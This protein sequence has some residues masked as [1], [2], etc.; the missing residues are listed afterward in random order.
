MPTIQLRQT[1]E[2]P[3]PF[4]LARFRRAPDLG[5]KVLF[6]SGGSAL[7]KLSRRLVHATHN[8]VH[9]ITPFDSGGSSA[10]L[11]NEFNML[12][13]GDLRNR[14]MAL[15]DRSVTGN[16]EIYELFNYRFPK[17]LDNEQ[18]RENLKLMIQ[19]KEKLISNIPDPM[20]K[21]IRTHLK[22]FEKRMT[23]TFDLRGASIGNLILAGGYFNYGRHIDPVIFLFSKLV[24]AKGVVRPVIN[25]DL[26]LVAEL[27]NGR[28][29]VGQHLMTGKEAPPIDSPITKLY[30][31]D[32]L[33]NISSPTPVEVQI[34]EKVKKVIHAAD[35][36]VYP[37]GSFYSSVIANLLP[38]GVGQAVSQA[39]C[40]KVYVPNTTTDPE[41]YGMSIEQS[42]KTL[43]DYLDASC[44]REVPKDQLLN[45][46]LI[47]SKKGKY[48]G[49]SN[50][51]RL[52]RYGVEVL[53]VDLITE[54]SAPHLD[55]NLVIDHLLSLC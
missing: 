19:G 10:V 15:A 26:H 55:E 8:S 48:P 45:F 31:T 23:D 40:A 49:I 1:F 36:I 21:I 35:L 34:R 2:I 30:L 44:T 13:V 54:E 47:D 22:F 17:D 38:T 42:V 52:R 46:V 5:P 28:V 51:K 9:L 50:I 53:D 3:D 24:E 14:L 39:G 41:Q 20:R 12:A 4:R 6:F 37:M 32:S 25:K 43:L 16:P 11:R 7:R 29:L 27:R 33:Q 18:L